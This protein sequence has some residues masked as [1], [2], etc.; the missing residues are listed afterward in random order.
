L[1]YYKSDIIIKS[2][3]KDIKLYLAVTLFFIIGLAVGSIT[4]KLLDINTKKELVLYLNRFFQIM[5]KESVKGI[6]MFYQSIKNNFQTVFFIWLLSITVIGIPVTLFIV[7]FRG[8]IIGFSV[9]LF[10]EGIGWK[11]ILLTMFAI[12][13]QNIIYIPCILGISALSLKFSLNVLKRNLSNGVIN[14]YKN[15]ILTYTMY[16]GVIFLIMSLGSAIEAYLS[17]VLIKAISAYIIVQ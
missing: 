2:I 11:G 3:K 9:A 16:I 15:S 1:N 4:V 12:L 6:S 8:F 13:P 14:Q 7:S 17:P 10:I 5:D